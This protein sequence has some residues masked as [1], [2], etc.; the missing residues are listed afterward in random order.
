[1]L[2]EARY[3]TFAVFLRWYSKTHPRCRS[4]HTF[5]THWSYLKMMYEARL[6]VCVDRKVNDC[7]GRVS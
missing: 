4:V 2:V 1:M 5:K 7:I 3:S 6:D